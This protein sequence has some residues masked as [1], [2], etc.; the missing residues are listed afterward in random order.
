MPVLER[1]V[2]IPRVVLLHTWTVER[3]GD[4]HPVLGSLGLYVPQDNRAELTRRC[5]RLLAELGLAT[6]EVL[7]PR[8]RDTLLTL[9]EPGRELYCWSSFAD[10][11][12]DR[13]CLVAEREGEAV[14]LSVHED[15]V[16][17]RPIDPRHLVEEFVTTLPQTPPAPVRPLTVPRVDVENPDDHD[18][19]HTDPLAEP[20]AA[21]ELRTQLSAPRDAA[22]QLYGAVTYDGARRRS[23]PLTA[24]DVSGL[25]RILVFLDAED[26]VHRLPGTPGALVDT[27]RATWKGL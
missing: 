23:K 25:G 14:A 26:R 12:H 1:P 6:D 4:P 13:A 19:G 27:L 17:L 7:T 21:D 8:F 10:P 24:I 3:L 2:D 20:G 18:M 11:A 9:A 16:T 22:H 5:L 15:T